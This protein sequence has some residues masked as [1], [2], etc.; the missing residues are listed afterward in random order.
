MEFKQDSPE[1]KVRKKFLAMRSR[2]PQDPDAIK[3]AK[4]QKN[5]DDR[6]AIN[7]MLAQRRAS[8]ATES[9]TEAVTEAV[10]TVKEAMQQVEPVPPAIQPK[11]QTETHSNQQKRRLGT[12]G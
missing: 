5:L 9:L 1:E 4:M 12:H 6:A 11:P 7:L 3:A 10:E 8:M 2:F